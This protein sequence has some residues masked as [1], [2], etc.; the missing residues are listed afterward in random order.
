MIILR[1]EIIPEILLLQL[2]SLIEIPPTNKPIAGR[3]LVSYKCMKDT[4]VVL[5]YYLITV[6]EKYTERAIVATYT[7]NLSQ[8][9]S[10][11]AL[12]DHLA[13]VLPLRITTAVT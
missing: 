3:A 13:E 1:S 9:H 11:H 8:V 6:C 5:Y 4:K 12:Y 2:S 10:Y 7:I